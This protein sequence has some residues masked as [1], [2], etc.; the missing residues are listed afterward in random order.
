MIICIFVVQPDKGVIQLMLGQH[1]SSVPISSYSPVNLD[2]KSQS[3][4]F[5]FTVKTMTVTSTAK[6]V[7]A[8][9]LLLGTVNDQVCWALPFCRDSFECAVK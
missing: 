9:Q 7:T 3:Y 4:F 6:G 8:R 2:V 1:N 5:T